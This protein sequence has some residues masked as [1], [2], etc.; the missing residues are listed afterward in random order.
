M[1]D[2]DAGPTND[3]P[4][5]EDTGANADNEG[6][7]GPQTHRIEIRKRL[8]G[9]RL[10]KYLR[11]KFPR[12]SRTALQ[13]YIKQGLVTVNDLPTKAGPRRYHQG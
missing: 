5:E 4:S 12:I 2:H 10:D 13:L 1:T 8:P 9:R 6:D 7:K 3:F 11:S